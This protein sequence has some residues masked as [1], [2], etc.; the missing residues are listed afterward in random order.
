[1]EAV[2]GWNLSDLARSHAID[3]ETRLRVL[4]QVLRGLETAHAAGVVHGNLRPAKVLIGRDGIVKLTG[5]G[6]PPAVTAQGDWAYVAPEQRNG[7]SHDEAIDRYAFSVVAFEFVTGQLPYAEES[8]SDILY[9]IAMDPPAAARR[10]DTAARVVF[11][12]ALARDPG[13]RYPDLAGFLVA[14]VGATLGDG[15]G[16]ARLLE[17]LSDGMPESRGAV[18]VSRG[19]TSPGARRRMAALAVLGGTAVALE[20]L[21]MR[22]LPP[23]ADPPLLRAV[24]IASTPEGAT[25]LLDGRSYGTTPRRVLVGQAPVNV[26]LAKAGHLPAERLLAPDMSE[27]SIALEPTEQTKL[28]ATAA[29]PK[30]ARRQRSRTSAATSAA[31]ARGSGAKEPPREW[32][33]GGLLPELG[34]RVA[35]ALRWN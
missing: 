21:G 11:E 10:L 30:P 24:T 18:P 4:V 14:L 31:T 12:R 7:A 1:M 5:F 19:V 32:T 3:V 15:D 13:D 8:L 26:L 28:A 16:K 23:I 22:S 33:A 6:S 17:A 35:D 2:D 9:R 29:A 27:L 25:V 34:R 20:L